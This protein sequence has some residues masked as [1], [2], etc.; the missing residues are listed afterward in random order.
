MLPC[1]RSQLGSSLKLFSTAGK[2][3]FSV[4]SAFHTLETSDFLVNTEAQCLLG[5]LPPYNLQFRLF[6]KTLYSGSGLGRGGAEHTGTT[7]RKDSFLPWGTLAYSYCGFPML[8][9]HL[10]D[11]AN[12]LWQVP[13]LKMLLF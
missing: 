3:M 5:R 6:L 1:Y 2:A 9:G 4:I 13:S 10:C 12:K 8:A 7:V 11:L